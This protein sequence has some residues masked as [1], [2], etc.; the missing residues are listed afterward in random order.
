MKQNLPKDHNPSPGQHSIMNEPLIVKTNSYIILSDG[1]CN[2]CSG[3]VHFVFR[4]DKKKVFKFAWI[5]DEIAGEILKWLAMPTD[6]YKTI[7]LI[8][9]GQPCFKSNAFL[10][11]VKELRSPWPILAFGKI[12]PVKIRDY[13][14][15]LVANNRYRWFGRKGAC[16]MPEGDLADC[17]LS[18]D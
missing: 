13:I 9:N 5:Q 2:L 16:E 11:I 8:K 17:F 4:R 3:F 18:T 1:V 7:V 14:Y 10:E 12:L 6:Q 15:D